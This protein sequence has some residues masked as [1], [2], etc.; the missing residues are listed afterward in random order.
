MSWVLVCR[1]HNLVCR[2]V[3]CFTD[4]VRSSDRVTLG[5]YLSTKYLTYLEVVSIFVYII[6]SYIYLSHQNTK[7]DMKQ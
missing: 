2:E 6:A 7:N 3:F 5:R 1:G 4:D